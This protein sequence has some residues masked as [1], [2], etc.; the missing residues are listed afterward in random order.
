MTDYLI[1]SND[2][3]WYQNSYNA[4]GDEIIAAV[5]TYFNT[6]VDYEISVYVNNVLKTT[7][8]GTQENGGYYTIP[9]NEYVPVSIGDTFKVVVK[10]TNPKVGYAVV[11]ISEYI[12]TSNSSATRCYYA[13][14]VSYF[15]LDGTTWA[16]LYNYTYSGYDHSY[17]SQ[18][19]CLKAFTL[20]MINTTI[21]LNDVT[22]K[23]SRN[24]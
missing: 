17:K 15:S 2:T 13:P 19:A 1:T 3:I 22:P 5:S 8:K 7:Q 11:P 20:E 4:T 21:T 6:T 18:V 9:L 23:V 10:L 16:D 12:L 14:G 24:Y